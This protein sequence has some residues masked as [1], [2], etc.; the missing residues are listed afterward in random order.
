M[1]IKNTLI[2]LTLSCFASVVAYGQGTLYFNGL[3]RPSDGATIVASDSWRAVGFRTGT[4]EGGYVLNSIQLLMSSPISSAGLLSVTFH[5]GAGSPGAN[6]ATLTGAEPTLAGTYN[7]SSAGLYMPPMT[8]FWVVLTTDAPA[9]VGYHQWSIPQDLPGP[10][11][12]TIDGWLGG[13]F[14]GSVNGVSWSAERPNP[15]QFAVGATAVPEPSA[16]ALLSGGVIAM[17]MSHRRNKRK[18]IGK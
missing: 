4:N 12:D 18:N 11:Y 15:F 17:L 9:S 7:Y 8:V 5:S 10:E 16:I 14:L 2:N 3:S 6:L 13:A 1:K